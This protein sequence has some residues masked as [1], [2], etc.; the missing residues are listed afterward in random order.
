MVG[1]VHQKHEILKQACPEDAEPR[2]LEG[3]F[4]DF[5][6]EKQLLPVNHA[7]PQKQRTG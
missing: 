1:I 4:P 6:T 5:L 2:K 7:M 3:R